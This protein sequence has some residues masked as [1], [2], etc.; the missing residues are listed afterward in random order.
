MKKSLKKGF[1]LVELVIVIAVIAILSAVLI[2]TFG[3]VI[4]NSKNTAAYENA[5]NAVNGYIM[6]QAENENAASLPKGYIV[7]FTSAQTYK[8]TGTTTF[9]IP[10]SAYVFE[11][12][13]NAVNKIGGEYLKGTDKTVTASGLTVNL[14][15]TDLTKSTW[16]TGTTY[17]VLPLNY[18][19]INT[20]DNAG[21]QA[22]V[23]W[24]AD[25]E[26]VR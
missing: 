15:T 7:V 24:I 4:Q 8:T 20:T 2:P 6:N 12:D 26:T 25:T 18:K 22:T 11:Y 10:D 13:G 16:K 1:T 5:T 21:V 19:F 17:N 9:T 14:N 23:W 3:N